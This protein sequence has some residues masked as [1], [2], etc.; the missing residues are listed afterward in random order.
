MKILFILLLVSSGAFAQDLQRCSKTQITNTKKVSKKICTEHINEFALRSEVFCHISKLD[1]SVC[2]AECRE[3][4]KKSFAS[5]RVELVPDCG[6]E[7]AHYKRMGI[8]YSR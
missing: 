2:R 1:M 4:D 5:L 3:A 7:L 6:R 8:T